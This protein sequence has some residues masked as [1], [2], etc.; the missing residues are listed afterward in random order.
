MAKQTFEMTFAGRPL[1]VEVGQVAKQANGAVGQRRHG[2]ALL[3]PCLSAGKRHCQ[4]AGIDQGRRELPDPLCRSGRLLELAEL[5]GGDVC[6]AALEVCLGLQ[7]A[8]L[9]LAVLL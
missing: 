8:A 2:A 7:T 9:D 3:S 6:L 1:V 4:Q 5:E